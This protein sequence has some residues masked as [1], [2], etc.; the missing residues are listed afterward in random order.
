MK[1]RLQKLI[2]I[3]FASGLWFSTAVFA[4]EQVAEKKSEY[5][6]VT[7]MLGWLMFVIFVILWLAFLFKKMKIG[8]QFST[9]GVIKIISSLSLG[10]KEKLI[11]V[12]VGEEQILIGV[13]AQGI[14]K[15]HDLKI[16]V[17]IE[18]TQPETK[19]LFSEQLK[20]VLSNSK[21]QSNEASL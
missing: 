21:K 6:A 9:L 12:Q 16:P 15:I 3:L 11:L 17:V 8:Q 19:S 18:N 2:L 20:K 14:H 10:T 13:S 4:A 1:S 5:S 7:N